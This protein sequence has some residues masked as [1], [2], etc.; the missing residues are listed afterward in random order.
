MSSINSRASIGFKHSSSPGAATEPG[1][2][3]PPLFEHRFHLALS[4]WAPDDHH[5]IQRCG[6]LAENCAKTL[7]NQAARPAAL[8]GVANLP[9][10]GNAQTQR[11]AFGATL[12]HEDQAVSVDTET[13]R[14]DIQVLDALADAVGSRRSSGPSTT[15]HSVYFS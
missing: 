9:R 1:Q 10:R 5:D 15:D 13:A 7:T 2:G 4:E 8:D 11:R 12:C 6:Q 3:A 14:L